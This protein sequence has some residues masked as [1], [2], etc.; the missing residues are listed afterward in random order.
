MMEGLKNF[1]KYN[2]QLVHLDLQMTGLQTQIIHEIGHYLTR[3]TSLCSIHLCGNEGV[4]DESVEWIRKR[5]RAKD[6][7]SA[8]NI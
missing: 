6:N 3:A 7:V 8:V 4:T 2:A 1:M 5:I